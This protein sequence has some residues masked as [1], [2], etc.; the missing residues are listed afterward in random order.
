MS[1]TIRSAAPADAPVI[2]AFIR[3]L[4]EYERLLHEVKITLPDVEALVFG[5]A[6]RVFCD[7]AETAAGPVGFA[8]WF[9]S[10]STFEGRLGIYLEDLY[11][12]PETRGAGVGKALL[13]HLARRCAAEGLAR[14]EWSVL[15][16]NAPAIAFY[17]GLGATAKTDWITRRLSGD[18]LARLA[19]V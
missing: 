6:P 18:A 3:E 11:V 14:L 12:R 9:Y 5:P 7:I 4:A 17:D 1:V 15:D 10:V 19:A 2:L 13:A 8:L 16:W